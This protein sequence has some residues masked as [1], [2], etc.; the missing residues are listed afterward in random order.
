ML[1][2]SAE[3]VFVL[4]ADTFSKYCDPHDIATVT[5]FG[6]GAGAA[7]VSANADGAIASVGKSVLGTDG[8]GGDNLIV[9]AG[10]ARARAEEQPEKRDPYL[11]MNGPEIFS[12]TLSVIQANIQS[13]L[14][15][16]GLQWNQ[17]D[18]YFFH[19]ANRFI[20]NCLCENMK[21]PPD[22]APVD[23]EDYGNTASASLPILL[24]RCWE[25]GTLKANQ[26]CVL[27]GF[28]V[29]YSWAATEVAW[30]R[31]FPT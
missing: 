9:R 14:D 17:V 5:I 25:Q 13:L 6:D 12:F 19:Q 1:S 24:R 28:G 2:R 26:R 3:N 29:G 27:A 22:K 23:M 4:A 7:L 20:L 16:I 30:L 10:A 8:R 15:R 18:R 21:I 31:N 11:R